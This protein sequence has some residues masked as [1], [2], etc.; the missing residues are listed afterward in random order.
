MAR[1]LDEDSPESG[2]A[3]VQFN[4]E[5]S[6]WHGSATETMWATPSGSD[7]FVIKNVPFYAY[8]VSFGDTVLAPRMDGMRI[9]KEV[10]R[11]S[12][13]STYRVLV[14]GE[15]AVEFEKFWEPLRERGCTYEEGFEPL[16]AVDVPTHAD[17]FEVYELLDNGEKAGVW[18]FEEGHCG[19]PTDK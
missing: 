18:S 12:G 13:H 6:A 11:R 1:N 4:L 7:E 16:L 19:H 3:K 17:I 5:P 8:G 2:M 10:I 9:F 15:H 14:N